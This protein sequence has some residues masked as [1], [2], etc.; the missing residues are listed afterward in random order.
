[1][2]GIIHGFVCGKVPLGKDGL[3]KLPEGICMYNTT[4]QHR[5]DQ[6]NDTTVEMNSVNIVS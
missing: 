2:L 5:K 1:M 4:N 3:H 6:N